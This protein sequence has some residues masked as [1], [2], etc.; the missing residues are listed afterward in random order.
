MITSDG[1]KAFIGQCPDC[2]KPRHQRRDMVSRRCVSCAGKK[3]MLKRP[4]TGENNYNWKGG[5]TMHVKGYVR[6]RYPNH[7]KMHNGYVFEHLLVMEKFLGRNL[8]PYETIH[9]KNGIKDDNRIENLELWCRPHPAGQ[10]VEDLARWVIET[11]PEFCRTP[12]L[13]DA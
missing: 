6:I 11:Y 7:P 10:R 13:G 5:K 8:M 12:E 4:Q 1:H 9:H 2:G 3:M